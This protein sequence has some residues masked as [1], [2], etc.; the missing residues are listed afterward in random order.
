MCDRRQ[1]MQSFKRA[2]RV[3]HLIHQE[4]A[5]IIKFD[6]KD[7]RVGMVTVTGVELTRDC[8]NAKVFVS[9]LGDE[10]SIE[11][12]LTALESSAPFIRGRLRGRIVMKYIPMLLFRHDP[13]LAEGTRI[14]TLLNE[15]RRNES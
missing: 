7:E 5:H 6:L 13:S 4:V 2:D 8:K 1:I 14:D 11:Q 3:S 15:I 10:Q 9:V 12:A